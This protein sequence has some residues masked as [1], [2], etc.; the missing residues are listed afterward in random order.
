MTL[1]LLLTPSPCVWTVLHV[2][3]LTAAGSAPGWSRAGPQTHQDTLVPFLQLGPLR[4][5]RVCT[6]QGSRISTFPRLGS[7]LSLTRQCTCLR[8]NS[9]RLGQ[10][11][12][13]ALIVLLVS[14]CVLA[15]LF[16]SF[17][18]P[19]V[20]QKSVVPAQFEHSTDIFRWVLL[21]VFLNLGT[22]DV[23]GWMI[24][25]REG[26]AVNCKMLRNI[27]GLYP[28]K[29]SSRF[30]PVMTTKDV[31]SRDQMTTGGQSHSQ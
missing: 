30:P 28:L 6:P 3:V 2:P 17:V 15:P 10:G 24:L 12:G 5:T 8:S 26:Y 16:A 9:P 27:P 21:S 4:G 31:S 23:L 20:L 18:S 29:A 13:S 19:G 1:R 14:S 25:C 22:S 11:Q 7:R